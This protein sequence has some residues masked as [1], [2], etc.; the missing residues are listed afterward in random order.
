M[1][2]DVNELNKLLDVSS[3]PPSTRARGCGAH[4]SLRA[5]VYSAGNGAHL[6]RDGLR[7]DDSKTVR[8]IDLTRQ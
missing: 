8:F 3:L 2:Y 4:A 5:N 1:S 7:A 6:A